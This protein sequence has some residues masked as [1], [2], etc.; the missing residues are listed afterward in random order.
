MEGKA[1]RV[2]ANERGQRVSFN[3]H[4]EH[5][6]DREAAEAKLREEPILCE[7][8]WPLHSRMLRME[9]PRRSDGSAADQ[10]QSGNT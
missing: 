9:A 4:D 3:Q 2:A 7:T 5:D 8:S 10:N 1:A 6:T